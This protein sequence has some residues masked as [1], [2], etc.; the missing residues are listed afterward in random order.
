MSGTAENL[1]QQA[2]KMIE[3]ANGA[4]DGD[5]A[6]GTYKVKL[7]VGGAIEGKYDV[8]GS[9]VTFSITKKPMLVP[10]STIESFLKGQLRNA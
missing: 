10:C 9:A 2:K 4:F 6:T 8:D 5:T 7:P 1:V 3:D